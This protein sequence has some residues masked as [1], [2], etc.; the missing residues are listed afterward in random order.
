[1]PEF[2]NPNLESRGSGGG[3]SSSGGDFRSLMTFMFLAVALLLAFQYFKPREEKPAP[4]A[5]TQQQAAQ[6]AQSVSASQPASSGTTPESK[7]QTNTA[8]AP[9]V[10][11]S[12]ETETSVEIELYRIVFTNR[13]AQVKHW[14]LK[15]YSDTAGKPLDLVQPQLAARFGQP[16]SFF[17]YPDEAALGTQLNQALYQ[18]SATGQL[19]APNKLTFHYAQNGLDVEKTFGFDSSY[20]ISIETKVTRNGA[21]IRAL[22]QW[23]A[24]LGDMEEFLPSST[25]RS[26]LLTQSQ[27]I[28]STEGK[29]NTTSAAKVSGDTTSEEPFDY[30]AV[31]DLY[32][33]AAF[34][35]ETPA[36]ATLVTLHNTVDVPSDLSNPNSQKKPDPVIGLAMG[37]TSG[38]TRLR[39]FAGPKQTDVLKT[40][41]A[42]DADG[43]PDGPTLEPLIQYGMWTIIAKPLYLA[44]RWLHNLLGSG[45]YNWG[46]AII[47]ITVIFNLALLPTRFM[48][49][50]SSLKMMR[51][52]PKV[53]ALKKKYAHLKINDPKRTEMNAEMMALYKQEGVNMYGGCLPLLLQMPLFFAYYRVLLYAVELRQAKWFW[54]TDLSAPDP[55]HILPVLIILTM[56]LV[57]FLT[58]SPGMDP[59]QRRMMA[60]VMPVFMGFILWH[61]ASG[62][63]LY[64][65]T[66]NI[67]NLIIQLSINRSSMG[68]EMHAIAAR[69]AA[70]K[71]SGSGAASPRVIQ[72]RR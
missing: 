68:K 60:I 26:T 24:G 42:S 5:Q 69:R 47:I 16:L 4:A 67:I 58:P 56:A 54:L 61:Y 14:F 1:L 28:T 9:S 44:L 29:Q 35:P 11:A 46:W 51:I 19:L 22:T 50:K 72:G 30:A 62:L 40:I 7:A 53:E 70:K 65:I 10:E 13:G 59:T 39:L 64:W 27:I 57:Q 17:T 15:K 41:H 3:G 23:P 71:G 2:K 18:P 32:F 38:T 31:T 21:P 33:A 12:A 43:K 36:R 49:M 55:L 66:G 45:A 25:T 8:A 63:A 52:Q 48:M 37:D 6:P 20:V 34:L